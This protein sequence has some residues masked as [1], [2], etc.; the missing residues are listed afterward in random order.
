ML[1]CGTR[2]GS[3][4]YVELVTLGNKIRAQ[5]KRLG[6]R[7][8][9]AAE[10]AG[11]SRVTLY[12]IEKGEPSVAIGAYRNA[13]AV[14]GLELEVAPTRADD[15]ESHANGRDRVGSKL[16]ARIAVDNYPQLERLA[17]QRRTAAKLTPNEALNLYERNW[18]HIDHNA[19]DE[20]ERDLIK[21]LV[22]MVGGGRLLV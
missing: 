12:R 7:A 6:V 21:K 8:A 2:F 16:P 5:R 1:R 13:M 17:W 9:T 22:E 18:R 4:G 15:Q 19:M 11:M 10:A 20:R 3:L 14:L